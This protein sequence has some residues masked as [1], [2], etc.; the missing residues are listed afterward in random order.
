MKLTHSPSFRT[1]E[2]QLA[3]DKM[4]EQLKKGN[5]KIKSSDK[6]EPSTER[7]L[8]R[9]PS[10]DDEWIARLVNTV[11]DNWKAVPNAKTTDEAVAARPVTPQEI[12]VVENTRRR[13]KNSFG[14]SNKR[15]ISDVKLNR[16]LEAFL[17]TPPARVTKKEIEERAVNLIPIKSTPIIEEWRPLTWYEA[18][19][20]WLKGNKIRQDVE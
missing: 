15:G 4:I 8:A 5:P 13:P 11:P 18:L 12:T 6:Q 17:F 10:K 16:G 14:Q 20:H 1:L 19:W 7:N 2:E 3:L 9:D